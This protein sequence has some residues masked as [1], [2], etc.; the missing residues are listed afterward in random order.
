MS[1]ETDKKSKDKSNF[2]DKIKGNVWKSATIILFV[3]L[4]MA[5]ASINPSG[6]ITMGG[7]NVD[8]V[9]ENSVNY[10]NSNLIQGDVEA[11]LVDAVEENGLIKLTISIQGQQMELYVS[12]DGEKMFTQA[13]DM[14]E[15]LSQEGSSAEAEQTE[16]PKTEK[17]VVE[18]FVSPYCPYGLQYMKGLIPVYDVFKEEANISIKHIG[19]THMQ[20]E[21]LETKKELCII[22]Q[23]GKE[24]F[25]DYLKRVVYS[26][27]AQECYNVYHGFNLQTNEEIDTQDAGN[28][29]Y[30]KECMDPVID[31][32][33]ENSGI[34]SSKVDLCIDERGNELYDQAMQYASS[35][36]EVIGSPTPKINGI[37]IPDNLRGR[38]PEA[39]KIAVCSA[40]TTAPEDCSETLSTSTPS[41]GISPLS[42]ESTS[43]ASSEYVC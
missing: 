27:R 4:V 8:S 34:D 31:E 3:I 10:I 14:T 32:A 15:S 29:T 35:A 1:E 24:I 26:E 16:I 39:I 9:A 19:I 41:P 2:F 25:F 11:E 21:E 40:F 5:L 7:N 22:D 17:P 28:D 38:S 36:G 30:F 37:V 20:A 33:M 6:F 12:Q 42:S 18:A 43:S 23:Y 13:I